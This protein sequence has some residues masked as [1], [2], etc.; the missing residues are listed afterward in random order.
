MIFGQSQLACS[1]RS[2]QLGLQR[3]AYHQTIY[4]G[5]N[6]NAGDDDGLQVLCPTSHFWARSFDHYE[7]RRVAFVPAI[8]I[9]VR[10]AA[11]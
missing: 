4:G 2:H 9:P 5:C 6:V 10:F 11:R 8:L 3:E 7:S 1:L